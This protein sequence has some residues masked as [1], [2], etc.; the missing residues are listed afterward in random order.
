MS[1]SRA[2]PAPGLRAWAALALLGVAALNLQ[3]FGIA[4]PPLID[5]ANHLARHG[6]HCAAP[7]FDG[8]AAHYD[9][10]LRWVPNLAGDLVHT[11]PAACADLLLTRA[12]LVQWAT[13]GLVLGVFALHAAIWR[14]VS[15]WP[16]AAALF[17]HNMPLG[18]GFENYVLAA[19]WVP[20]ALALWVVLERRGP[21]PAAAVFVP[22]M[23]GLYTLHLYAF[24]FLG[25]VLGG[26]A[27]GLAWA[28]RGRGIRALAP[29]A[30]VAAAG[31]LPLAHLAWLAAT[32][33]GLEP[34]NTDYGD[35][36]GKILALLSP[37]IPVTFGLDPRPLQGV[38]VLTVAAVV[39]GLVALRG[40]GRPP[41]PAPGWGAALAG[42][43]ALTLAMPAI[44]DGIWFS[45]IR[46]PT[47][48]ACLFVAV[49]DPRLAPRQA[50][51]FTGL[52]LAV[53]A[54]RVAALGADWRAHDAEVRQ[55]LAAAAALGPGDRLVAARADES[56][57]VF[58][59]SSTPALVGA[60]T[61]A[62]VASLFQGANTLTPKPGVGPRHV[63]QGLME[64]L[65]LL[66]AEAAGAPVEA[67]PHLRDWRGYFTHLLVIGEVAAAAPV[68]RARLV[69]GDDWFRLYRLAQ[70]RP[71]A[72]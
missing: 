55:V 10:A 49:T 31:A 67:P 36:G 25:A 37:V 64:S 57:A 68:P 52:L 29:V 2:R 71:G 53:L 63:R 6:I 54:L 1:D 38:A 58:R 44:L 51:V 7:G 62:H 15:A 9:F 70:D 21:V 26:R 17:A 27:L 20:W 33:S 40:A 66:L 59:H 23:A 65:D 60:V 8:Q 48:L 24:G 47:L 69:A 4:H 16:A 19:A 50:G 56:R 12:V 3:L 42:G 35:P 46:F 11:L 41:V 18:F 72:P 39:L 45:D 43:L 30:A 13:T 34:G 5:W 14:R 28:A 22:V 32:A 61:G